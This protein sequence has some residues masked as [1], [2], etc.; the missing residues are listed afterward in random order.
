MDTDVPLEVPGVGEL[1]PTV[2]GMEGQALSLCC[3]QGTQWHLEMLPRSPAGLTSHLC[4][5]EP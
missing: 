5:T 2:L 1:L 3:P 4:V